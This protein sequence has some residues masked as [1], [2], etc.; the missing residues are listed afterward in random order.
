MAKLPSNLTVG[1]IQALLPY[2]NRKERRELERL[3]GDEATSKTKDPSAAWEFSAPQRLF[4]DTEADIAIY[5]GAAGAGKSYAILTE[6]LKDI[7]DLNFVA[8]CFRRTRVAI[9]KV[10]SLWDAACDMYAQFK[11]AT[12]LKDLTH[13]FP[14]GGTLQFSGMELE[15]NKLDWQGTEIP[16]IMFDELTHFTESQFFYMLSRNRS[17]WVGKKRVRA[18][19]N[20]DADSWVA[21]FISWWINQETGDPIPDRSGKLRWFIRLDGKLVWGDSPQELLDKHRIAGLAD[22]DEKQIRPKSVTFIRA[23]IFD[24]I[25]LLRNNP[26]Y[27][28]SLRALPLVEQARLLGGNWK[29]RPAA[30]LYFKREWCSILDALPAGCEEVRYW[31]LASTEKTESNDPDWTVGLKLFRHPPTKRFIVADVRRLREGPF[32]VETAIKNTA[33]ADGLVCRIGLPQDPGQAG[34]SQAKNFI[35]NLAGHTVQAR[36]ERGDKV[37]RFGPV[38]SQCQAGNVA[39]L[40]APWNDEVFT[41]LEGF[42]EANH[43]DDAD[44][45]AGAFAMYVDSTS[46]FLEFMRQESERVEAEKAA[47]AP[48]PNPDT[49]TTAEGF[50][51]RFG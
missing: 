44:A 6:P 35:A 31:D 21:N 51:A 19:T 28:A 36:A 5:G 34:K 22:D 43:D 42:P 37:T 20:P 11:T 3:I 38:S 45:L 9:E 13:T 15:K 24:N 29:I 1:E 10:G 25:W 26:D 4:R 39:F 30:G 18:T 40:R 12:N 32:A 48:K 14:G 49:P 27:L 7:S 8:V 50:A 16:L 23:T 2:L 46:G 33:A 17:K 47:S 41:S